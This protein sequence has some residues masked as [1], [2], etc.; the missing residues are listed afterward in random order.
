MIAARP[1]AVLFDVDGTLVDSSY[2]HVHSW[3]RV[4]HD[5]GIAADAWRITDTLIAN[6]G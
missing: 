3:T 1:P 5:V 6:L 2:L 4:F